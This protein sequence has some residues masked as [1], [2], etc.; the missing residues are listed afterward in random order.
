M[1]EDPKAI[2]GVFIWYDMFTWGG[3][4]NWW[5]NLLMLDW[6]FF[7]EITFGFLRAITEDWTYLTIETLNN[8]DMNRI[9]EG[10]EQV[11]SPH[12][13]EYWTSRSNGKDCNGI[14]GEGFYCYCES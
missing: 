2:W 3:F 12:D 13:E 14:V 9:F 8:V 5:L 11:I 10:E 1:L 6:A 7:V 4:F